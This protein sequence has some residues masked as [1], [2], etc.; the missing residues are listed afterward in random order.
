MIKTFE[1]LIQKPKSY[2]LEILHAA[3]G[4]SSSTKFVK[5]MTLG[6]PRPT[7]K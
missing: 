2:D 7:F 6:K 3:V 1:N 5:M 4:D